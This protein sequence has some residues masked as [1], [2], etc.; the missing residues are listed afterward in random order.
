MVTV[1]VSKRPQ[2]S[3]MRLAIRRSAVPAR[4]RDNCCLLTPASFASFIGL[5]PFAF[6][7]RA[8]FVASVVMASPLRAKIR[9]FFAA[10][11]CLPPYPCLGSALELWGR[12]PEFRDFVRAECRKQPAFEE[13]GDSPRSEPSLLRS[14]DELPHHDDCEGRDGDGDAGVGFSSGDW[15]R[16]AVA[17]SGI[18]RSAMSARL[19][20]QGL[21]R[22]IQFFA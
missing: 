8:S 3:R 12:L 2:A 7:N 16:H 4:M 21:G 18:G 15:L 9:A 19:W 10:F 1:R 20:T 5:M 17:P 14:L 22:S 6:M 13:R 11:L